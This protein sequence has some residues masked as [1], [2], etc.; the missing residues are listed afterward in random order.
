MGLVAAKTIALSMVELL[1]TPAELERAQA[2][3]RERTA[4][5]MLA[6]LLPADLAPPIDLRWPEWLD[7]RY[8]VQPSA[9]LRWSVPAP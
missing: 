9:D 4:A 2:E 6:P 7:N 1:T 5:E 8:P 3:H